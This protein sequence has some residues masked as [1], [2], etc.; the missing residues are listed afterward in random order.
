MATILPFVIRTR[1]N[2]RN[3]SAPGGVAAI[4]IFPGVRYEHRDETDRHDPPRA[5]SGERRGRKN[6]AR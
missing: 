6:K 1:P 2:A 4:I 3:N 5:A